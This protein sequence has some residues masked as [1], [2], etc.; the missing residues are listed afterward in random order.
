MLLKIL[1][2][3]FKK[4]KNYNSGYCGICK[5][6]D[7]WFGSCFAKE[8]GAGDPMKNNFRRDNFGNR[9]GICDLF[10]NIYESK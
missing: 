1:R 2:R 8:D 5:H 7:F 10:S 6:Y 4:K 9:I 3:I